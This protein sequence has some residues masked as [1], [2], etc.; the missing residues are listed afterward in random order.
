M[1]VGNPSQELNARGETS[2]SKSIYSSER[3]WEPTVGLTMTLSGGRSFWIGP[4]GVCIPVL[5]LPQT[6]A[7]CTN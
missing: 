2:L 7:L 3:K 6:N 1:Q 5:A 4:E